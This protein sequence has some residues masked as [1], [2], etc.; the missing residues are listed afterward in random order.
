[1]ESQVRAEKNTN[2]NANISHCVWSDGMLQE[3]SEDTKEAKENE[4]IKYDY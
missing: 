2:K 1:M 4:E 3:E